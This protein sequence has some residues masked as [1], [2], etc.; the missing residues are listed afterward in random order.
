LLNGSA[1]TGHID[2]FWFRALDPVSREVVV[3][4]TGMRKLD[5][6]LAAAAQHGIRLFL[7]MS[8]NWVDFGGIDQSLKWEALLNASYEA[9]GPLHDD[10]FDRPWQ[11]DTH[12][13][14][15]STLVNRRNS[16]TGIA[17]ADDPTILGYEVFTRF[18]AQGLY[19][20]QGGGAEVADFF[21]DV[22]QII[23]SAAPNALVGTGETGFD[24]SGAAY[25]R[26]AEELTAAG[27]GRAFDG[28]YGVSWQRNLRLGTVDFG[29]L[30]M[31]PD[32][33]GLPVDAG[34]WASLG[35]AWVR[36]HASLAGITG[37]P[38]VVS[39][40]GVPRTLLDPA[41]RA[42]ALD[43]WLDEA[44]AQGASGVVVGHLRSTDHHL[45]LDVGGPLA[46]DEPQVEILVRGGD[47]TH[48]GA[49][50]LVAAHAIIIAIGQHPQQ[51]GL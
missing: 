47:D 3:N 4:E 25:G 14:W 41:A 15:M 13:A 18:D 27:L 24:V 1:S 39:L 26:A 11:M 6:T 23:Q 43:A 8:N 29:S 34:Q 10:F 31:V 16:V 12:R 46:A 51:T 45:A 36:G 35:A 38:L 48:V 40:A 5:A 50:R 42:A 7:T 32:R 49:D 17:Y 37:K 44:A 33:L 20:A 2:D 19:T 21:T 28:T 9:E 30:E 22:T